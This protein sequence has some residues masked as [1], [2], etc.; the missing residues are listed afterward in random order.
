MPSAYPAANRPSA[1]TVCAFH[2]NFVVTKAKLTSGQGN[3]PSSCPVCEHSPVTPDDCTPHK[4]LRTTIKVFLRTEEKKRGALLAKVAKETPPETPVAE[5]PPAHIPEA[6]QPESTENVTPTANGQEETAAQE[7]EA[8]TGG[9]Q[10]DSFESNDSVEFIL[11]HQDSQDIPQK[12]IE[13]RLAPASHNIAKPNQ[14]QEIAPGQE[15]E[16]DKFNV[17][18]ASTTA[19]EGDASRPG[20]GAQAPNAFA[21]PGMGMNPMMGMMNGMGEM[22]QMQQMQMMMA[23]QSG[24]GGFGGFPMMGKHLLTTL[25][26]HSKT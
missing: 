8:N 24:M 20:A 22:N 21:M 14:A 26:Y 16:E 5:A 11:N 6:V 19:G 9:V 17:D 25:K 23:M 3:L 7:T 2:H 18:D 10:D 12:S 15:P 13:V 4:S 1:K